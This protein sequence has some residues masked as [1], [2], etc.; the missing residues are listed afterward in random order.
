[1]IEYVYKLT[2]PPIT[3][4]LNES[5]ISKV[6]AGSTKPLH[7]S[8]CV[9]DVIK[10][11][12]QKFK[13]IPWKQLI[14]FYKPDFIGTIHADENANIRSINDECI[15]GINFIYGGYGIMEYWNPLDILYSTKV[16]DSVG[17]SN[18][19]CLT[20]SP[21]IK[22]Y[23]TFPGAYLVNASQVH[24]AKGIGKRYALTLRPIGS[25]GFTWN[26]LLSLFSNLIESC[27]NKENLKNQDYSKFN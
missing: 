10:P 12:W 6:F 17:T 20:T 3:E 18:L 22:T 27:P 4:I 8:F 5:A 7:M 23:Y 19:R 25:A 13:N 24:R 21:P 11:E 15:W 16:S 14:V 26:N 2:L 1:M 9:E